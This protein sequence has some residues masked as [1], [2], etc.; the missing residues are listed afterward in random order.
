VAGLASSAAASLRVLVIDDQAFNRLVLRDHLERLGCKVEESADGP[1]AHLLLQARAHHMAFVDLDLPGLDGL[2]L[3]RHVRQEGADRPV[4]LVA[5]TASATRGIEE[6]VLAAGADAFLPKPISLPHLAGLLEACA[7]RIERRPAAAARA[8]EPGGPAI[9]PETVA[10]AGLFAELPLTPDLLRSLH[11]ELDVEAQA[12]AAS[13]RQTDTSATRRHAHRIAS[14]GILAR[15]ENLLQAARLAEESLQHA[16][17][18]ASRTVD[19]L[20]LAARARI[21][22]LG[23]TVALTG[24][25]GRN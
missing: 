7:A 25:T 11:A 3:I 18:E 15:D 4:F 17:A 20:Q 21:Q 24:R 23:N 9:A 1:S 2:A 19:A 13:W 16:P 6:L 12:L 22:L 5:T 8:A 10:N 14:L